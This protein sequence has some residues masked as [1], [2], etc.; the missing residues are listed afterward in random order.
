MNSAAPE[1]AQGAALAD[2]EQAPPGAAPPLT[3]VGLVRT[4]GAQRAVDGVSFTLEPGRFLSLF[5]PNGAG[6]STLLRLLSGALRPTH[7][8]L[9]LGDAPLRTR[10][11][12]WQSRIGV[13]SHQTFLYGHL[14]ARENLRFF[15]DLYD[16][17]A[18]DDRIQAGLE[19]VD[20]AAR[21][22]DLARNYSR[23]MRQRL[24]LARTLL[25]DPDVVLL[26]EPFT[27]LDAHASA[28]LRGVLDA[29]R[30][31]RRTVVM[32]TH[33]LTEGLEMADIAAIQV[34]GRIELW[35]D[36]SG[37]SSHDFPGLYRET[38]E[39]AS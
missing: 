6:K 8:E 16:L 9:R 39:T 7:G 25:H 3:A 37:I 2:E 22:D 38:V 11:P 18:I 26:D 17:D 5:G 20:L 4:F 36:A 24:A 28:V 12:G 14:T 33:N 13:L 34:R 29:L 31:G 32:V 35:Q 19:A 30:D 1:V 15:G 10:E 23:G 27:G 21:G